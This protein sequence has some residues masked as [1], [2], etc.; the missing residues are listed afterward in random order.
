MALYM[1]ITVLAASAITHTSANGLEGKYMTKTEGEI[2]LEA[3]FDAT[4]GTV[5]E[6]IICGS[7]EP[8]V[9]PKMMLY[10]S[11]PYYIV[12]DQLKDFQ[13]YLNKVYNVCQIPGLGST[14]TVFT[15]DEEKDIVWT[16][17]YVLRMTRGSC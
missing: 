14:M 1:L 15:Y 17:G 4:E 3:N 16:K 5:V 10:G 11:N 6:T 13:D 12:P 2:C 9:F 8:V 7:N